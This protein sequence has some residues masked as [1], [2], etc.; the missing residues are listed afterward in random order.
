[1]KKVQRTVEIELTKKECRILYEAEKLLKEMQKE[2]EKIAKPIY[3]DDKQ[4]IAHC[5]DVFT[6]ITSRYNVHVE[7][8][9]R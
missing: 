1:M 7:L 5:L 3:D 6:N 9:V 2:I 4:Q 8:G